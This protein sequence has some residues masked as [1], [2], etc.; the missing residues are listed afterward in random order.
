MIFADG[1]CSHLGKAV[2]VQLSG[3]NH[4]SLTLNKWLINADRRV[5]ISELY[6]LLST[7][8]LDH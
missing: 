4:H 8:R 3:L 6:S 1:F 2:S 5:R 7:S